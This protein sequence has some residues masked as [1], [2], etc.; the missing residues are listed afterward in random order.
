M[1]DNVA[2]FFH[3]PS[4]K[5]KGKKWTVRMLPSGEWRC[6]CPDFIFTKHG[7]EPCKHVKIAMEILAK[8]EEAASKVEIYNLTNGNQ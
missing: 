1:A 8:G 3:I 4:S 6:E 2:R 5:M 7:Q